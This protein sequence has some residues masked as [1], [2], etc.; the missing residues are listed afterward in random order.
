MTP[1]FI[2]SHRCMNVSALSVSR[3]SA[4]LALW[5]WR[6]SH[7]NTT[8]AP[9]SALQPQASVHGAH[10]GQSFNMIPACHFISLFMALRWVIT[11]ASNNPGGL[12]LTPFSTLLG[13]DQW[14][15]PEVA[16]QLQILLRNFPPR[17]SL[18]AF[19]SSIVSSSPQSS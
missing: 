14:M 19:P 10:P 17:T 8:S 16:G 5:L 1:S 4:S 15:R 13:M 2:V 18:L 6:G 7:V 9:K 3:D 11:P 12:E